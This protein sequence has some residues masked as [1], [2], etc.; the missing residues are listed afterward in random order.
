MARGS[1]ALVQV[2]L[3]NLGW[4]RIFSARKLTVT[5]RHRT[6]GASLSASGGADLR[7]L[8]PQA[9]TSTTIQIPVPIPASA[10][11]GEHD[12]LLGVPDLHATTAGDLRY[13]IQPANQDV[14]GKDQA[15]EPATARFR[16]GT[17]L[18]VR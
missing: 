9:A 10:A 17:R 3:R 8:A 1:T 12:V 18:E 13:A 14:P 5:L 2:E 16:V 4:S 11:T 6:T 15:W 7:T